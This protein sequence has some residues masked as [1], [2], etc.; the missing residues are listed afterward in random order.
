MHQQKVKNK[1]KRKFLQ[2]S[3]QVAKRK[4]P[5]TKVEEP[6]VVKRKTL[7]VKVEEL[8]DKD[9]RLEREARL[10]KMRQYYYANRDTLGK[11]QNAK[12]QERK[13]MIQNDPNLI[14]KKKR[15]F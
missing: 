13:Q 8:S 12:Y 14:A 9:A 1:K 2:Q 5:T 3:L 6:E 7:A 10:E 4:T 15:S 11:Q